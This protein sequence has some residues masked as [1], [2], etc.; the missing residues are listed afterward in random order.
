MNIIDEIFGSKQDAENKSDVFFIENGPEGYFTKPE[1][2]KLAR[3]FKG[4]WQLGH[5]KGLFDNMSLQ[6][7]LLAEPKKDFDEGEPF[8]WVRFGY[9]NLRQNLKIADSGRMYDFIMDYAHGRLRS[10]NTLEELLLEAAQS[11]S[12]S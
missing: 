9:G 3:K 10:V 8:I 11:E 6:K 12:G 4:K 2:L 1:L 7:K 5:I